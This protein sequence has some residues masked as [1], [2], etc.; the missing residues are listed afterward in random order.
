MKAIG[1]FLNI[2]SISNERKV[3]TREKMF[4]LSDPIKTGKMWTAILA[5]L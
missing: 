2:V 1:T 4:H 3:K 5:V